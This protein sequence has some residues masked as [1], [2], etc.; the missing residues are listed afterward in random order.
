MSLS[1]LTDVLMT[2]LQA[3]GRL[4]D[5]IRSSRSSSLLDYTKTTRSEP[6]TLVDREL[7]AYD[8]M[9]DILQSM[10][11][12]YSGAY[13]QAIAIAVNVGRVDV[14]RLL[15]KVNVARDPIESGSSLL[16][17]GISNESFILPGMQVHKS[18]PS[19]EAF[20]TYDEDASQDQVR[21]DGKTIDLAM[22]SSNLSV[23][24]L[25][26]VEIESDGERASIPVSVRLIVTPIEQS[27]LANIM[28][29][30]SNDNSVKERFYGIK[31]GRLKFINDGIFAQDLI[32]E[33][34]KTLMKD[35]SN[36]Y[37]SILKRANKN[38]LAGVL[39]LNPSV[40][41]ASNLAVISKR[42]ASVIEG[43][44]RGKLSDYKV[45]QRIFNNCY[46]MIIAVVDTD[47]DMVTF[48]F[49]GIETSTRLS[50]KDVK[51]VNKNN[52]DVGEITR[53]LMLGQAP[54]F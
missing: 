46:L 8:Q 17:I 25:F 14:I 34:R 52:M 50:L 4:P 27:I 45:R 29:S 31:S 23:G 12:F 9:T 21:F 11:S 36:Q 13:L 38:R 6:I 3:V 16:E 41:T 43:T 39:S 54:K 35:S 26:N 30:L 19:L 18:K 51:M 20:R 47:Y 28:S 10:V 48:H 22:A 49:N 44:I 24:K 1:L 15:D 37:Q 33:H 40:A 32:K 42:T 7:Y 53:L 5:L 2:P